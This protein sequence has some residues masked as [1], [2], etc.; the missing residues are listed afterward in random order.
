MG[1]DL[2][3]AIAQRHLAIVLSWQLGGRD[4]ATEPPNQQDYWLGVADEAVAAMEKAGLR[5]IVTIP[6]RGEEGGDGC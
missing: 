6:Q 3:R 4:F 5:F 2:A 1:N